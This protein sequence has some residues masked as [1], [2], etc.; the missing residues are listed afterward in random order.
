MY[1][2]LSPN[3][4]IMK[5]NRAPVAELTEQDV[6]KDQHYWSAYIAPM[7][8]PWLKEDTSVKDICDYAEKVFVERNGTGFKGDPKYVANDWACRAFSKL[9]SSIAGLYAERTRTAK[10]PVERQRMNDAAD[11]AFRQAFALCPYSPEAAF[12]Y[13]NLLISQGRIEDALMLAQ[14]AS[15]AAPSNGQFRNLI[16]ELKRIKERQK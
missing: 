10:A 5:I 3:G 6:R 2:H 12:R 16:Q 13:I 1:P 15:D 4:L 11:F 9:R 7:I 8:G 14:T